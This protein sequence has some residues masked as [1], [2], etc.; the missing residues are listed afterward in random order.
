MAKLIDTL[1]D[2]KKLLLV[3]DRGFGRASLVQFLLKKKALFV[4]RVRG[5]VRI[6]PQKE[7]A[8]LLG[9]LGKSLKPEVS[10]WLWKLSIGVFWERYS[11]QKSGRW[12]S[13][14]KINRLV[15]LPKGSL[16]AG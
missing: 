5:D 13:V 11:G 15:I 12:E 9:H 7:K 4:L 2:D 14:R 8:L 10:G 3:A 1:P 16:E 6:K